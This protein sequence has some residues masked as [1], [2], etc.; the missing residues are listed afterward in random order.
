[1]ENTICHRHFYPAI[2]QTK[3][4][5]MEKKIDA[6]A[7]VVWDVVGNF[8]R[9]DRFTD[10]LNKCQ[11]I[12]E[13]LGQVRVKTFDSGD[14]VVD[15]ISF[16]DNS[17]MKMHFNIISTSLNLRN[18]WELMRVEELTDSC[19]KVVWEMAGEPKTGAQ[20]ELEVF[21]SDFANA[22]LANVESIC[23][24]RLNEVRS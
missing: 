3:T 6:P 14:Y 16:R 23:S 15:Q 20:Q 9:F 24:E 8:S 17:N 10:G 21:L 18:L 1:M 22:A 11:M 4:L 13:G 2:P 19:C 7:G 12:G 5:R